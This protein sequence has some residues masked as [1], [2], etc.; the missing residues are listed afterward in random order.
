MHPGSS[1]RPSAIVVTR[2]DSSSARS[3]FT[4]HEWINNTSPCELFAD[5]WPW[6]PHVASEEPG[7][8]I[9]QDFTHVNLLD[10]DMPLAQE[11]TV[12][13]SLAH[14]VQLSDEVKNA[15]QLS[16][17]VKWQ[18]PETVAGKF[19]VDIGARWIR[20]AT[21]RRV[22]TTNTSL[23]VSDKRDI[24]FP[25]G[26]LTIVQIDWIE[27]T[28]RVLMNIGSTSLAVRWL[29][30]R[31]SNPSWTVKSYA[32][33]DPI[34]GKFAK[35][36]QETCPDLASIFTLQVPPSDQSAVS[37]RTMGRTGVVPV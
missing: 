32:K 6:R 27:L 26:K 25:A 36:I 37:C 13:Y 19:G 2:K 4:F 30:V 34:D 22:D 21:Q 31:P 14:Q 23:E 9:S 20:E 7:R 18:S 35:Y 12:T 3:R 15:T 16:A 33:G 29:Q 5:D 24:V 17:N 10:A 11:L 1:W 8:E 28:T